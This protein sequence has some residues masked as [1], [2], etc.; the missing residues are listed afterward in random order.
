[1]VKHFAPAA[2]HTDRAYG[3]VLSGRDKQGSTR[4]FGT[5]VPLYTV[6]SASVVWLVAK[7]VRDEQ[8]H[9]GQELDVSSC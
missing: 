4:T 1:M 8:Q 6:T 2:Q 9:L 3:Y 7:S 5:L